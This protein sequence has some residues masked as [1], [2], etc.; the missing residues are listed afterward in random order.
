[1]KLYKNEQIPI[2]KAASTNTKNQIKTLEVKWSVNASKRVEKVEFSKDYI[3][4]YDKETNE[5]SSIHEF[6]L[7]KP[8]V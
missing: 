7:R 8:K 3:M 1:M 4:N 5:I 2:P 6:G